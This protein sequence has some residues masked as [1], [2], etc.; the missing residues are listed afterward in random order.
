MTPDTMFQQVV[1]L[2]SDRMDR[3]E[4]TQERLADAV[5]KQAAVVEKV[6]TLLAK[7]E[8][9]RDAIG[10]A[11]DEIESDRAACAERFKDHETRLRVVE[12]DMPTLRLT[13]NWVI[14]FTVAGTGGVCLAVM[15]LVLR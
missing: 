9:H 10:R 6:A 14:G 7:H 4:K 12:D 13:R 5:E 15:A 3:M 1:T 2:L 8:E 11:F